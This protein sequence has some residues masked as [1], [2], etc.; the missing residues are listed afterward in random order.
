[1]DTLTQG[2]AR[3]ARA[4]AARALRAAVAT[5]TAMT[6]GASLVG[7]DGALDVGLVQRAG[8]AALGSA[9][10]VL[11]SLAAKWAGDDPGAATFTK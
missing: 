8:I 1:M 3:W 9:V 5:F 2:F 4:A 7:V 11:I 6:L 10:S